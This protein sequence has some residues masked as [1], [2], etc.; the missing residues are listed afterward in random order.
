MVCI[1]VSIYG[2]RIRHSAHHNL[3]PPR[4]PAGCCTQY[5]GKVRSQRPLAR[6]PDQAK[7]GV[8]ADG[9]S[10]GRYLYYAKS[11]FGEKPD[12]DHTKPSS[13]QALFLLFLS[14]RL[15][16]P[17]DRADPVLAPHP[18]TPAM[19]SHSGAGTGWAPH[20][21]KVAWSRWRQRVPKGD[22]SS[23]RRGMPPLVRMYSPR[24]CPL[25]YV[26]Q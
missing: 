26:N 7:R 2:V 14:C 4:L 10:D 12:M 9:R 23:S 25:E 20:P 1:S 11:G 24:E 17:S 21:G 16:F 8:T 13:R 5:F 15:P 3:A 19:H 22:A 18:F 6:F